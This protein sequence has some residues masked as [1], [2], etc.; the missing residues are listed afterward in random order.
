MRRW[1]EPVDA[2]SLVAFRIAFGILMFVEVVRYFAY[3]WIDSYFIVPTFH[4]TY[5]GFGWV[6]PWAG[7]GMYIHFAALGILALFVAAGIWYRASAALFFVGFTHIF[8]LDQARYLNHFYLI[9]L[10]SFL[11][12][13]VPAHRLFS[14]DA[15]RRPEIRSDVVPVW[16]L[17]L[18]RAQIA[19]PYFYGG[20]AKLN[21]DWIA[22]NPLRSWL[23]AATD[24]P[25]VGPLFVYEPIVML[26]AFGALLF[27][28]LVVPLLMWRRT[29]PLG[30]GLAVMFHAMNWRLFHIGIFPPLMI[31]AT[32]LFFD[33]EWPRRIWHRVRP[34]TAPAAEQPTAPIQWW[35]CSR[36]T[37]AFVT[38]YLIVQLGVPLRHFLYPGNVNWTEEGHRFSWHM[39]L[40]EKTGKV[41]FVATQLATGATSP[42]DPR[43]YL[44]SWQIDSMKLRP[45]ML[46][47]FSQW[48]ADDLSRKM[49]PVEIRVRAYLSL[50]GRRQQWL[51]DPDVNLAEQPRN[52]WPAPW[53][54]QL[55]DN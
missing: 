38:S 43:A 37:M 4:F 29:R 23:A 14:V 9:A 34:S 48:A 31:A 8:L 16:S 42:V 25:V 24:F 47:Q 2:A 12:V 50:N 49:S 20:V 51:I 46:L 11:L 17:T 22:G 45:D 52:L 41:E 30:F 19:I 15:W 36:L 32:C 1:F 28:L 21:A 6:R 54:V 7:P 26:F 33:P 18:L 55:A 35:S 13:A 40:R 27:D 3:G 44:T 53:I 39:M 5:F 10:L